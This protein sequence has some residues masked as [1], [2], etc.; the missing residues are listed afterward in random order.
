MVLNFDSVEVINLVLTA[1]GKARASS[2]LCIVRTMLRGQE[3]HNYLVLYQSRKIS[4]I[5]PPVCYCCVEKDNVQL[6]RVRLKHVVDTSCVSV[7]TY[8]GAF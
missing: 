6:K 1:D 5:W 8:F 7:E 3:E 2:S 4:E